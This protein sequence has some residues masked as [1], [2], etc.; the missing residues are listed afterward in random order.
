MAFILIGYV[1][2]RLGAVPASGA[3]VLSKMENNVFIPALVLSTFWKGFTPESFGSAWTFLAGGSVVIGL[4]IPAAILLAKL[5]AKDDYT[6]KIY[7]YGLSFSNFGFMGNAVVEAL[8]PEVFL[9][10][11]IFV[12]PFWTGIYVWGVPVLLIPPEGTEKPSLKDRLK[13]LLNPMFL[14]VLAGMLVGISGIPMPGFL[15]TA[16]SSLGA[17]MSPVAM[18]LTGMTVAVI[19]L[20]P[21]LR[22]GPVWRTSLLRLLAIPVAVIGL[23]QFLPLPRDLAVCTVCALAMPLGLN[24]IVIPSAYGRDTTAAAGMALVSHLLSC[25]TIPL[26]FLLLQSTL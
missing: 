12:L 4:S 18:L 6:R 13:P 15:N 19:E 11:L 26:V 25:L 2:S 14:S 9:E 5:C 24:A 1:V 3:S 22:S 17:C 7:T 20:K 16:V 21:L 23:L 10:Y 8:F